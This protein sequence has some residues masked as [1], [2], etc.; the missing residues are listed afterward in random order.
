MLE[1]IGRGGATS[2]AEIYNVC[3]SNTDIEYR[4]DIAT[5]SNTDTNTDVGITNTEKYRQ[6]YRSYPCLRPHPIISKKLFH[7]DALGGGGLD[8][9]TIKPVQNAFYTKIINFFIFSK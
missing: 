5:F 1:I 9:P 7:L 4:N 6:K 3:A 8:H 2:E